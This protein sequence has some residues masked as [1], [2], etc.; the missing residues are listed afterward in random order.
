M[1]ITDSSVRCVDSY[2][3]EGI[4]FVYFCCRLIYGISNSAET[5]SG[6]FHGNGDRKAS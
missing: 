6:E 5:S 1:W 3:L 4:M 2:Y